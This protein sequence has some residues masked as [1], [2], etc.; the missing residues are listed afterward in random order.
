MKKIIVSVVGLIVLC[1]AGCKQDWSTR[2]VDG[3]DEA[4]HEFFSAIQRE[5]WDRVRLLISTVDLP[6]EDID[7]FLESTRGIQLKG[8]DI[9]ERKTAPGGGVVFKVELRFDAGGEA[10]ESVEQEVTAVKEYG[11]VWRL[12]I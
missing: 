1:A 11:R 5:D 4:V 8:F 3:P 9:L 12:R 6:P 10:E 2:S 7:A